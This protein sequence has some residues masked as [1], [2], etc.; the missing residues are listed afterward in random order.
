MSSTLN[1]KGSRKIL[2]ATYYTP[3]V[4]FK[5][6]D[7]LDL[8]D[9]TIVES[10]GVKWNILYINYVDGR[11]DEIET[12]YFPEDDYKDPDNI[13]IVDADKTWITYDEDDEEENINVVTKLIED[14][15]F[16]PKQEIIDDEKDDDDDDDEKQYCCVCNQEVDE[17]ELNWCQD[18][19]DKNEYKCDSCEDVK[20]YYNET[21]DKC[22][23]CR[24]CYYE[25]EGKYH[26]DDEEQ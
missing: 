12:E 9:E 11:T 7:G 3:E 5:L 24:E 10:Y 22:S 2:K 8:E 15:G 14:F 26:D 21:Y 20:Q 25:S 17:D 1:V 6:P 16:A 4:Y 13:E 18:C 23:V 19:R